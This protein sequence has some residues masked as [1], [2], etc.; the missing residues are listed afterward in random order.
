MAKKTI[1]AG[2]RQPAR[3]REAYALTARDLEFMAA[4]AG[5]VWSM[6][7]YYANMPENR[8]GEL[9][10]SGSKA[11][12]AMEKLAGLLDDIRAALDDVDRY[13]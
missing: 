1:P 2:C 11:D 8:T 10:I 4:Q 5:R 12:A 6:I 3:D 9:T 13:C 7:C